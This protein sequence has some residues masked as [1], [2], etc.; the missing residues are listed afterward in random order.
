MLEALTSVLVILSTPVIL[1]SFDAPIGSSSVLLTAFFVPFV[2]LMPA[3]AKLADILGRKRVLLIGLLL[4]VAGSIVAYFSMTYGMLI[5]G[6]IVQ[7]IGGST[8]EPISVSVV[9]DLIPPARQGKAMGYLGTAGSIAA[10]S[11]LIGGFLI[12]SF[13]WRSIF[14]VSIFFGTLA[15]VLAWNCLPA[16]PRYGT[17]A[18]VDW[19]GGVTLTLSM[20]LLVVGI[21][22]INDWGWRS[23]ASLLF[24]GGSFVSLLVTTR[25]RHRHK[26][27]FLD[28]RVFSTRD[29]WFSSI[30]A[31]ASVFT[32]TAATLVFPLYLDGVA[33]VDTSGIGIIIF[34]NGSGLFIGAL[35]GGMAADRWPNQWPGVI[36][37]FL[38]AASM[39]LMGALVKVGVPHIVVAFVVAGLAVGSC[40][41]PFSTV[42]T[43]SFSVREL[44]AASGAF[45]LVRRT[46]TITGAAVGVAIL[47]QRL[48]TWSLRL[49]STALLLASYRDTFWFLSMFALLMIFPASRVNIRSSK[50]VAQPGLWPRTPLD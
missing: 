4:Y 37:I 29:F 20:I 46:G 44:V 40:F 31:A 47:E 2:V 34:L 43:K 8:Y 22:N 9:G 35:I 42:I 32:L 50:S 17:V 30:A 41:A 18:A 49:D 36:G 5:L 48:A 23:V 3:S 38:A 1:R 33:E 39:F 25:F 21:S 27:P 12:N 14:V 11:S 7:G 15:L 6:R 13:G 24:F 45:N 16:F 28:H 19:R 10:S 26:E